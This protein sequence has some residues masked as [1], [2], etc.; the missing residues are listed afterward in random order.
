MVAN[1]LAERLQRQQFGFELFEKLDSETLD[2]C[3]AVMESPRPPLQSLRLESGTVLSQSQPPSICPATA[4]FQ[5]Y[6]SSL[7]RKT[8]RGNLTE[9]SKS[10][11]KGKLTDLN[12]QWF[13]CSIL[14]S[15]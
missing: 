3:V 5:A 7:K 15:W 4:F 2:L 13:H 12:R 11:K 14:A 6:N 9:S 8:H 10:A 1:S